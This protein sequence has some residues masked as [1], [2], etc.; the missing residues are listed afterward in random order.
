LGRTLLLQ[1]ARH[2][3]AEEVHVISR[4][5]CPVVGRRLGR[6]RA[7][8]ISLAIIGERAGWTAPSGKSVVEEGGTTL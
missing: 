7:V 1:I 5:P 6:Q 4:S 3:A 2:Q 8:D